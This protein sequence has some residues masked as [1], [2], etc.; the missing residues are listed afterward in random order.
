VLK[1]VKALIEFEP[2]VSWVTFYP[3]VYTEVNK[4]PWEWEATLWYEESSSDNAIALAM[5]EC[6][7][8]GRKCSNKRRVTLYLNALEKLMLRGGFGE[9][10]VRSLMEIL[11]SV[12][13][14]RFSYVWDSERQRLLIEVDGKYY[15][16]DEKY[17]RTLYWGDR[18]E[19]SAFAEQVW[20]YKV[21]PELEEVVG[22]YMEVLR[23]FLNVVDDGLLTT[24][25]KEYE[26]LRWVISLRERLLHVG[27]EAETWDHS[28]E[29]VVRK[30]RVA[31]E[32]LSKIL[33]PKAREIVA[34]NALAS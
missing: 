3:R 26:E 29:N 12:S 10:I 31:T 4:D 32:V 27:V 21:Y 17:T 19:V 2:D 28:V 5:S 13:G 25:S 11:S 22:K 18:L 6:R 20:P 24:I 34:Y 8:R 14:A 33:L 15:A 9:L 23:E 30:F 7:A 1:A 16:V